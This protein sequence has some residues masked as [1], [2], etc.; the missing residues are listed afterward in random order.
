M[1]TL[2]KRPRPRALLHDPPILLLDEVAASLDR[3]AEH[4]LRDTLVDLAKTRT[5]VVSTHTPALLVACRHIVG[6]EKGKV[7]IA[8]PTREVLAKMFGQPK[9]AVEGQPDTPGVNDEAAAPSTA[10]SAG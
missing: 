6:M 5:V 9:K 3:D 8:G 4:A 10:E 2:S 7:A 1:P